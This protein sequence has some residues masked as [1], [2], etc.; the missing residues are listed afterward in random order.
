M[1]YATLAFVTDYDA[2]RPH[3]AGVEATEI[4]ELIHEMAGAAAT[5]LATAI[6]KRPHRRLRVPARAAGGPPDA[7]VEHPGRGPHAA[8]GDPRA[9]PVD[10]TEPARGRTPACARAPPSPRRPHDLPPRLGLLVFLKAPR[11]RQ[12]KTRLAAG[13]GPRGPRRGRRDLSPPRGDHGRRETHALARTGVRVVLPAWSRATRSARWR[14]GSRTTRSSRRRR[15]ATSARACDGDA[16]RVRGRRVAR[17]GRRHRLPGVPRDPRGARVPG[18]RRRRPR[19]RPRPRRRLLAPSARATAVPPVFEG[20]AVV[21][22]GGLRRDARA[23]VGGGPDR[24]APRDARRRRHRR[25]P[26]PL[27]GD[28]RFGDV[29]P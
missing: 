2:W 11:P 1:C 23:R 20:V 4:F 8:R 28:P 15:R 7:A 18:A 24:R 19:D 26:R 16:R 5:A 25:G 12:V 29:L 3:V 21:D 27:Q 17:G 6:T 9:V 13:P 22:A 14:R 10:V